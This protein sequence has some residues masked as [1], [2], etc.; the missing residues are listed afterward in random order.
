MDISKVIKQT[1]AENFYGFG[2]KRI[3]KVT[4]VHDYFTNNG[5]NRALKHAKSE[6]DVVK[7]NPGEQGSSFRER[8][9]AKIAERHDSFG[10]EHKARNRKVEGHKSHLS[11]KTALDS[12]QKGN[13][14]ETLT[15]SFAAGNDGKHQAELHTKISIK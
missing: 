9:E 6:K 15:K 13:K 4:L 12:L 2:A 10:V 3:E 7:R 5:S 14:E 11:T 1:I 8:I